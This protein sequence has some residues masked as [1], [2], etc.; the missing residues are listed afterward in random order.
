[1]CLIPFLGLSR[2]DSHEAN[3]KA[4]V[5]SGY[6]LLDTD[7]VLRRNEKRVRTKESMESEITSWRKSDDNENAQFQVFAGLRTIINE[8]W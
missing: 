7:V 1:M 6:E 5:V 3:C 4:K 2:T 8:H